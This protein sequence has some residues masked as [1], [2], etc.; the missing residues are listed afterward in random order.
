MNL[1]EIINNF[2]NL[3]QEYSYVTVDDSYVEVDDSCVEVDDS[4]VTV[5]NSY[6]SMDEVDSRKRMPREKCCGIRIS[7][8]GSYMEM[9]IRL[10]EY[11][12]RVGYEDTALELSNPAIDEVGGDIIVSFPYLCG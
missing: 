7:E 12:E 4:Y 2:C 8:G 11:L 10:T 5:E 9:F 1:R 6:V 3:Y